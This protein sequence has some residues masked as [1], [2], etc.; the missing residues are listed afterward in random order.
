MGGQNYLYS[1]PIAIV[2][3]N[4]VLMTVV[5]LL[6][7]IPIRVARFEAYLAKASLSGAKQKMSRKIVPAIHTMNETI[8]LMRVIMC[9]HLLL[10]YLL[11]HLIE[12][13][14]VSMLF[15]ETSRA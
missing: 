7:A 8:A 15:S 1:Q 4:G 13:V 12:T 10:P 6:I 9:N 2:G 14:F 11:S 5:V 3:Y